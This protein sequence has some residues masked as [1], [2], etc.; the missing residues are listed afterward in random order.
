MWDGHLENDEWEW[1]NL[2]YLAPP[3]VN[4]FFKYALTTVLGVDFIMY[5]L[6]HQRMYEIFLE[7]GIE[8]VLEYSAVKPRHFDYTPEQVE[9]MSSSRIERL[10]AFSKLV[11]APTR[12]DEVDKA[13][14][15]KRRKQLR[16]S[17]ERLSKL[18]LIRRLRSKF[19]RSSGGSSLSS[20][21]IEDTLSLLTFFAWFD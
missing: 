13:I 19:S 12:L 4:T 7:K 5:E 14:K 9:E 8:G 11:A 21:D 3:V 2:L 20:E 1:A 15:R 10:N 16:E 18:S 17:A 6:I